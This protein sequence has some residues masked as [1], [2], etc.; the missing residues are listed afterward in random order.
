MTDNNAAEYST[1]SK[2]KETELMTK[3]GRAMGESEA[4]A[5]KYSYKVVPN[6]YAD[7]IPD[8]Q[9]VRP[10]NKRKSTRYTWLTFFPIAF[11]LQFKKLVNI[12]YIVTGVLNFM[13]AITVNS[14]FAVLVPTA[15]IML[16]GVIKEFVGELKRYK[17]DKVVNATPVKRL[18]L[19]GSPLYQGRDDLQW[20]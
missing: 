11:A 5:Q 10:T 13:P 9:K 3:S 15:T 18:A 16:L 1:G 2:L 17:E 7:G 6:F 8:E 19:P 20:E 12:F 14:P 4:A